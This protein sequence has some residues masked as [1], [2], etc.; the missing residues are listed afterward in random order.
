MG[1]GVEEDV[2]EEDKPRFGLNGGTGSH[3]WPPLHG[4]R[5]FPR[6]MSH[7]HLFRPVVTS[8]AHANNG[9]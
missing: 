3:A 9:I 1:W 7:W 2:C 6:I 5:L 8:I 4:P